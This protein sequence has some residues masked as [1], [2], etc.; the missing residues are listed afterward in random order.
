MTPP[1]L[2]THLS[3][4]ESRLPTV[5]VSPS[6]LARLSTVAQR[7]PADVLTALEIRLGEDDVVDLSVRFTEP[8][9][10]RELAQRLPPSTAQ[11]FLRLWSDAPWRCVR[12]PSLW[13]EIDLR[14]DPGGT[15]PLPNLCAR[16]KAPVDVS[17]L[18]DTLMPQMQ[19]R[20]LTAA[21]ADLTAWVL[22]R[23][24]SD[25]FLMYVFSMLPRKFRPLRLELYGLSTE[26]ASVLIHE[27]APFTASQVDAGLPLLEDVDRLHLSFDVAPNGVLPRIGVEGSYRRLPHCDTR[28]RRLVDRLVD[29]GLCTPEKGTAL[30]RWPGWDRKAR[31]KEGFLVRVLSHLKLV[32]VPDRPTEAKAYLLLKH[33]D[34]G[35]S[36]RSERSS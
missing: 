1:T 21:Q 16:L 5:L 9:H 11:N 23:L 3:A 28:W 6:A 15:L 18:V 33:L 27:V 8:S 31:G 2:A 7:L 36:R 19:G 12:V 10:A 4:V 26:Q 13:L 25:A 17:W 35:G 14:Q 34:R 30:F 20:P 32:M 24:P 22:D 29:R